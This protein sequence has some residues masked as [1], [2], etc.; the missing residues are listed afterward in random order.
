MNLSELSGFPKV[1]QEHVAFYFPEAPDSTHHGAA[2]TGFSNHSV[3]E[4]WGEKLK[5]L[6]AR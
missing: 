5:S 2:T 3:G 6:K 1:P 4:A